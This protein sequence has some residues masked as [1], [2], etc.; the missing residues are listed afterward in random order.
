[1]IAKRL[2]AESAD[3]SFEGM[4]SRAM[5]EQQDIAIIGMSGIF[6]EA[7]DLEQ[8]Y[9]NLLHGV[10]SVRE[11]PQQRRTSAGFDAQK[12]YIRCGYLDRIDEFDHQF[13]NISKREA[14]QMDPQQRF[15]LELTCAAIENAGYSLR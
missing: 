8:F 13:F 11:M 1:M 6:P 9:L 4:D 12:S 10:D 14:E 15:A 7:A 5:R 3:L 2:R